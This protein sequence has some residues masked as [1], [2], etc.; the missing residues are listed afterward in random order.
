MI[1]IKLA[2]EALKGLR[3]SLIK[4]MTPKIY[5]EKRAAVKRLE[6]F[7]LLRNIMRPIEKPVK[8]KVRALLKSM[9]LPLILKDLIMGIFSIYWIKNPYLETGRGDEVYKIV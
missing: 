3:F 4:P 1:R 9:A 6:T 7:P 8:V 5:P 2:K